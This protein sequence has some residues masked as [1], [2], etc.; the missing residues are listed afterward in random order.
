VVSA[1]LVWTT[2]TAFGLVALLVASRSAFDAVRLVGVVYLFV[3][4]VR[5][6]RDA[7]RGDGERGSFSRGVRTP[8]RA[9]RQGLLSNLSNPKMG[10]FFTSLL[11]QFAS[12]FDRILALGVVFGAMTLV[13]L[14]A[15]VVAVAR[16]GGAILRPRV[17]RTLDAITGFVL[18]GFGIHLAGEQR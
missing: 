17:R 13:W 5:M 4:G 9:Y 18:V 12:S 7:L 2:A 16:V 11:P 8:R 10:V 15:Y 3:L 14:A 6:L 1:Q